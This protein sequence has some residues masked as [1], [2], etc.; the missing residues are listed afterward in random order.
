MDETA[1]ITA[2]LPDGAV[3]LRWAHSEEEFERPA[4]TY[5][6]A[7]CAGD[8]DDL[9]RGDQPLPTPEQMLEGHN[10]L[11]MPHPSLARPGGQK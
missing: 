11:R 9:P 10:V 6:L 2:L 4:G 1:F 3:K 8:T 5:M 7:P